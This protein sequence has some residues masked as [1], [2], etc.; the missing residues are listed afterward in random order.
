MQQDKMIA[1]IPQ[2]PN[3]P[4]GFAKLLSSLKIGVVFD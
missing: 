4:M 1:L 2:V 3:M